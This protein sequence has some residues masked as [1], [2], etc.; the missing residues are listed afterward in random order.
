MKY[1]KAYIATLLTACTLG[2]TSCSDELMEDMNTDPSKVTT[3]DP[4][5]QLTMAELQTYGD[6]DMV[7]QYRNYIYGFTQHLMGCWNTSN[8]AGRHTLD[9]SQMM[10]MWVD[11]YTKS[12]K[13]VIDAMYRTQDDPEQVNIHSVLRI[14]RVYL[15]SILTDI[16]GDIPYS[17][18][19]LG[20]LEGIDTPKFDTQEDIYNDFFVELTEA[21]RA[22]SVTGDDVTGDV[23]YNGDMNKWKKLANSLRMRFAMRISKVNPQKAQQEFESALQDNGGIFESSADDALIQYMDIAFSFAGDAYQ[24]YRGNALMILFY[25]NDP[26]NNQTYI[27]STM[28]NQMNDTGDPR[29][30]RIARFYFDDL[31]STT[32]PDGRVDITDEILAEHPELVQPCEPGA[33]WYDPWPQGYTSP[34]LEE[35]A[36]TNPAITSTFLDTECCPKLATNFLESSHPGVVMTYAETRFLLAEAILNGWN[37]S[38]NV[39]DLYTEGVRTSMNLLSDH[40]GCEPVTDEEFDTFIQAN[41]V[42][43]TETLQRKNINVQAW[44]L[45]FLNP[46]EAWANQR[47]SGYPELKSPAEYGFSQFL[48]NGQEIPTRLCY[49]TQEASYNSVH[50]NEAVERMGGTDS[51]NAHVWWDVD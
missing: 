20:Y 8:Y 39:S 31:M 36:L 27:C 38:G 18:A 6:L 15:M 2:I 9:N 43:V 7:N 26:K 28:Y 50:F 48:V 12:L 14:Y 17:E 1:Y 51:W 42:G 47:R 37:V 24:D 32:N 35:L 45:H 41:G 33:F 25:G 11:I 4:N 3:I 30:H 19:G 10:L 34:M 49:P 46:N 13:N 21:G 5:A 22:L 29:T 40:Y 44:L 16:Y 23:I